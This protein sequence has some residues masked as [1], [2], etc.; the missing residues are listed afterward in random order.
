[1]KRTLAEAQLGGVKQAEGY[2]GQFEDGT[3][4]YRITVIRPG[5]GSCGTYTAEN[6]AE[7]AHLFAAGTHMFLDHHAPTDRPER[8]VRDLAGVFLENA[9]VEEDGSLSALVRVFPSFNAIVREKFDVIGVSIN[10]WTYYEND[11]H[12]VVPRFDGVQSVD[13]VT[14]AGA[15]GAI[16]EV[17]ESENPTQEGDLMEE[18]FN[19]VLDTFNELAGSLEKVA[20]RLDKGEEIKPGEEKAD[21]TEQTKKAQESAVLAAFKVAKADLPDASAER[22][23][24]MLES[25]TDVDK[26]IEQ[27][28]KYIESV[29]KP[30]AGVIE[31]SGAPVVSAFIAG[32]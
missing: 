16:T 28:R 7:S 1:M 30:D 15:G 2:E 6:L 18:L 17:L 23:L 19:K 25:G 12:N 27:E 32:A 3:G 21:S 8:S 14:K 13:F 31:E 24:S 5:E 11:D 4:V 9:S 10:A 22:I 26:L 29:Q 20:D